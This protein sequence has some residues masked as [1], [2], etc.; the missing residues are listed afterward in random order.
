[1]QSATSLVFDGGHAAAT[2]ASSGKIRH[3]SLPHL[4]H[5][6]RQKRQQDRPRNR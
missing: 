6:V 5:P 4:S 2:T 3:S 1:M